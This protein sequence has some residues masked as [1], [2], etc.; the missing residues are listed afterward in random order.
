VGEFLKMLT[1]QSSKKDYMS[2]VPI[3]ALEVEIKR[4]YEPDKAKALIRK[5]HEIILGSTLCKIDNELAIY[6]HDIAAVFGLLKIPVK[7]IDVNG[8]ELAVNTNGSGVYW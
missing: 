7:F 8:N 3:P 6:P 1:F 4:V 5:F 2:D